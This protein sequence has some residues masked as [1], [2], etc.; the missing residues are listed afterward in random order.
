[1]EKIWVI[2]IAAVI[3]LILN[4]L[5]YK[6]L[7]VYYKNMIGKKMW[8]L[9]GTKVYFWQGS[10]FVSTGGTILILYLLKWLN[11]LTF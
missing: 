3:F 6:I 4:F 10:I 7:N 1:M 11:I 5:Y 9:G 8:K 2:T